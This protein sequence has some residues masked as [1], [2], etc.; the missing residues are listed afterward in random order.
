VSPVVRMR[1]SVSCTSS[2]RRSN[3]KRLPTATARGADSSTSMDL[4]GLGAL[5][6]TARG[7]PIALSFAQKRGRSPARIWC[8]Q[9]KSA[10]PQIANHQAHP[11]GKRLGKCLYGDLLPFL[12]HIVVRDESQVLRTGL[13]ALAG[14]HRSNRPVL[15]RS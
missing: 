12:A 7:A 10:L 15:I 6:N 13:D 5:A 3:R 11:V 2:A 1:L 14:F 9:Q 8:F 4:S